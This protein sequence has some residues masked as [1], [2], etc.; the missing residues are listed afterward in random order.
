MSGSGFPATNSV[1]IFFDIQTDL[2]KSPLS[3]KDAALI[4]QIPAPPD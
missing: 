3:Q 2:G 4:L 1:R